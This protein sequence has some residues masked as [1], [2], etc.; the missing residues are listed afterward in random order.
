MS[1]GIN[2]SFVLRYGM[3]G[4]AAKNTLQTVAFMVSVASG[5]TVNNGSKH[6]N[7]VTRRE[8]FEGFGEGVKHVVGVEVNT[9]GKLIN[10]SIQQ[11]NKL[12]RGSIGYSFLHTRL[13]TGE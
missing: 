2:G 10:A 12:F 11:V 3:I 6:N 5:P 13:Q 1:F 7:L 4:S 8:G 9:G